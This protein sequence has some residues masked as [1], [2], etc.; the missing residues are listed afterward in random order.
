MALQFTVLKDTIKITIFA[1]NRIVIVLNSC[2]VSYFFILY[3]I[4]LLFVF[5]CISNFI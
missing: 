3:C 2:V 4:F 5:Y 1:C